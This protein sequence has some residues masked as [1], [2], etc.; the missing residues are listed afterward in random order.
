MYNNNN[1]SNNNDGKIS[2]QYLGI[3]LIGLKY[4]SRILS[5]ENEAWRY[6]FA[7]NTKW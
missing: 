2:Y 4:Y 7:L 3:D 6:I 1:N 5:V